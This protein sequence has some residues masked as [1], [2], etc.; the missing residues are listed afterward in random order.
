MEKK[1]LGKGLAAL[2]PDGPAIAATEQAQTLQREALAKIPLVRITPG[3]HQPRRHFDESALRQLADSIR[4]GGV[5]QPLILRS[6]KGGR[7][8]IIAGERRW[9]AAE[10]AGLETVPAIITDADDRTVMEVSIIEN[11][12]RED[13]NPIEE[14]EAYRR[15]IDEFELSQ[16]EAANRVGKDRSTISN[17]LRL[18]KLPKSIQA[19]VT[20]GRLSA[21]H[22]R[23][24]LGLPST[25]AQIGMAERIIL[26]GLSVRETEALVNGP[27]GAGGKRTVRPRDVHLQQ[28][29]EDLKRKLETKVNIRGNTKTGRIEIEYYSNDELIRLV[30][31][32]KK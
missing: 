1:R 11:L 13:L 28:A 22:A 14:A 15:L 30:E 2:I 6:L 10:L 20:T 25:A 9:R 23:A 8:E 29:E 17:S 12:Q 24:L 18:L 19:D 27:R 32:L 26:K 31:F 4:T 16:E 7:Y 3:P 5:I 21:G